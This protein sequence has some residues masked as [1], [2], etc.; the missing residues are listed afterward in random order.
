MKD[1]TIGKRI[2]KI[3]KDKGLSQAR[4]ASL[5]FVSAQAVGKWELDKSLPDANMLLKIADE[6]GVD[7]KLIMLGSSDCSCNCN[8][9]GECRQ[10]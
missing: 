7:V 3:R 9:C 5:L 4:L 2:A 6:L 8:V 10:K 1:L